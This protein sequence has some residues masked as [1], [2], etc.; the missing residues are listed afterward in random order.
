[1]INSNASKSNS[2][3]LYID[4]LN[5]GETDWSSYKPSTNFL[6]KLYGCYR[7]ESQ[8]GE[9]SLASQL[10]YCEK[11]TLPAS[12][13]I[14]VGANIIGSGNAE[15]ELSIRKTDGVSSSRCEVST[16]SGGEISCV[17]KDNQAREFYTRETGDFFVCIKAFSGSAYKIHYE[18]TDP[19]GYS[20]SYS[21]SYAADYEIFAQPAEYDPV[22]SFILNN[23][24]IR[25]STGLDYYIE[26]EISDYIQEKYDNCSEGC[27]IP[28]KFT[29]E[30]QEVILSDLNLVVTT[31][32]GALSITRISELSKLPVKI[33]SGFQKLYLNKTN[34]SV[35]GKMGEYNLSLELNKSR[36]FLEKISVKNL[37]KI[38]SLSYNPGTVMAAFPTNF[39]V[40]LSDA[41]QSNLTYKWNFGDGSHSETKW[42][43]VVH[44]Y[45]ALGKFNLT[46]TIESQQLSIS[47][48]FEIEAKAPIQA[49]NLVLAE[50]QKNLE[51][52]TASI[53]K[54]EP[55]YRDSLRSVLNITELEEELEAIELANKSADSDEDYV[56]IMELLFGLD[57]PKSVKTT[58]EAEGAFFFPE[59]EIINLDI[60]EEIGSGSY[61]ESKSD[62]YKDAII[63]WS[64]GHAEITMDFEEL[65]AVYDDGDEPILRVFNL[66]IELDE[67]PEYELYLI[68]K[69]MDDLRFKED[70]SEE[71]IEEYVYITID[72]SDTSVIFSTTESI[73]FTDIPMFISPGISRLSISDIQ[74]S[75]KKSATGL[76]IVGICLLIVIAF[77]IYFLLQEWYD[78]KY[79]SHLFRNK[80]DLYNIV[81]YVH[82]LKRMGV[83]NE[84]IIS[85]LKRAKWKSEQISYVMKKYA[86]K[87]TGMPKIFPSKK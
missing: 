60:L 25:N 69:E 21:G 59:E 18:T 8:E 16:S 68:M 45:N 43:S 66:G 22:G 73:D 12:P 15:F 2:P 32:V 29:G 53:Q 62:K 85:R 27:I 83:G 23:T 80:N 28:I 47:K 4:V 51:N 11:I 54:L 57:I 61:E 41:P 77:I 71:S 74:E 13:R 6:T 55:F 10:Q 7:T 42:N 31:D 81:S 50:K 52:V 3:Q 72:D 67:E 1:M 78:K 38:E 44:K 39:S 33:T 63:E 17:P 70:Y 30:S 65:S 26:N 56:D 46:I 49:V 40:K 48:T 84:Q 5:D 34:F 86:G 87:K 79:E 58:S 82:T 24:E 37:T 64:Y 76:I 36:I 75:E 20:G 35:P 9:V 14:K 19:C